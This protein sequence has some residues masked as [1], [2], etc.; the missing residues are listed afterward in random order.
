MIVVGSGAADDRVWAS[1]REDV[2]DLQEPVE[3]FDLFD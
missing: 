1:L 3:E 2:E